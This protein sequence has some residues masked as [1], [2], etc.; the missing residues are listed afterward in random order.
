MDKSPWIRPGLGY[1]YTVRAYDPAGNMSAPSAAVIQTPRRYPDYVITDLGLEKPAAQA[2]DKVRLRARI[3]NVGDGNTPADTAVAV[4]FHIDG[5]V[6]SWGGIGGLKPGG[7]AEI[8]GEGGPH[9]TPFWTAT[10]GEHLLTAE[11]DDI[12]RIPEERDRVNNVQDK[13]IVIGSN[14]KGELLGASEEAPTQVDLT[15]EGTEDWVHWGL[16]DG[17]AVNRKTGAHGFSDIT[18]TGAGFA[19]WTGGFGVRS[20]WSDG[21]P[22]ASNPGANAS[23]WFNGVGGAYHFTAPAD[24]GERVLRIYAG[25]VSGAS[26]TLTA[27]LS[28]DSAPAYVSKTWTGNS[29]H[30]NWAPVAG[31]FCVVYTLRYHAASAGQVLKIEYKLEAEPNRFLGQARLG[32][33]TLS[34][35]SVPLVFGGG[36]IRGRL[37]Q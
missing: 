18:I 15:R 17:R 30:G 37:S 19:S 24:M 6:I 33:A 31:D 26:C 11:I 9:P 28:D 14:F 1:T 13:S 36:P 23:L 22:V 4:T 25:G 8:V 12:D 34:Q 32:A 21:S 20:T 3:R 27:S 2:G 5:K 16:R 7:E 29:G 10:E 35:T